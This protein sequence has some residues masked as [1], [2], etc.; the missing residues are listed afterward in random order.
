[1]DFDCDP[2]VRK[3]CIEINKSLFA[4][5]KVIS[6]LNSMQ[7]SGKSSYIPYR[8]SKLT[9]LLKE[10]VGGSSYSLM[11]ATLRPGDKCA[12]ENVSTLNYSAKTASITNVPA[13]NRDPR[14]QVIVELKVP[15]WLSA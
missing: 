9:S 10:G 15:L 8:E 11:I 4:L 14:A 2:V 6:R 1:M 5:R 13:K 3:E 7:S 12:E